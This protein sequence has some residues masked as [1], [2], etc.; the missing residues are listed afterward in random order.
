MPEMSKTAPEVVEELDFDEE[1]DD[2]AEDLERDTREDDSLDKKS[3][4]FFSRI[5]DKIKGFFKDVKDKITASIQQRVQERRELHDAR[6]N[7]AYNKAV[8]GKDNYRDAVAAEYRE[9]HKRGDVNLLKENEGHKPESSRSSVEDMMKGESAFDQID[10]AETPSDEALMP[11]EGITYDVA[12]K[13]VIP[14]KNLVIVDVGGTEGRIHA[15][16]LP[17]DKPLDAYNKGDTFEAVCIEPYNGHLSFSVTKLD[18]MTK[19][20]E[21][22]AAE[23][24]KDS[25]DFSDIENNPF[26]TNLSEAELSALFFG[27]EQGDV[28]PQPR[29][30]PNIFAKGMNANPEPV[31]EEMSKIPPEVVEDVSPKSE[32][33]S[34]TDSGPISHICYD[35]NSFV[36]TTST[37]APQTVTLVGGKGNIE[38]IGTCDGSAWTFKNGN[39]KKVSDEKATAILFQHKNIGDIEKAVNAYLLARKEVSQ[40]QN[41]Y[42]QSQQD[43][44]K[45]ISDRAESAF[46]PTVFH[47]KEKA[48]IVTHEGKTI[49]IAP[50][51][52]SDDTTRQTFRFNKNGIDSAAKFTKDTLTKENSID[53][54]SSQVEENDKDKGDDIIGESPKENSYIPIDGYNE[55][56]SEAENVSA[57]ADLNNRNNQNRE[58]IGDE[59]IGL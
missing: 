45:E 49:E 7:S 48:I 51:M 30:T 57:E 24:N 2:F 25:V 3:Q 1:K 41:L 46:E 50:M 17:K 22:R 31:A 12:V 42:A 37:N 15:S 21:R 56:Q 8:M 13:K 20:A 27:D 53:K 55:N 29:E 34:H 36:E 59:D 44:V 6:V 40:V 39:G 4:G 33:V 11:I 5:A 38:L 19:E 16:Q 26:N 10:K 58:D 28:A 23:D 54:G 35:V 52:H 32:P 47:Y 43:K 14:D 18:E 9:A